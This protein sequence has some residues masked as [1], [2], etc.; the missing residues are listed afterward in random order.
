MFENFKSSATKAE[1]VVATR[2]LRERRLRRHKKCSEIKKNQLKRTN[3]NG[4]SAL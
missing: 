1:W 4:L 2:Q 3:H